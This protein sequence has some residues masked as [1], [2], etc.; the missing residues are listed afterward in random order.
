MSRQLCTRCSA[1]LTYRV[2]DNSKSVLYCAA[3]EAQGYGPPVV[4]KCRDTSDVHFRKTVQSTQLSISS[5]TTSTVIVSDAFASS[6]SVDGNPRMV[7]CSSPGSTDATCLGNSVDVDCSD[8]FVGVDA[9]DSQEA[10]IACNNQLPGSDSSSKCRPQQS[11]VNRLRNQM[12]MLARDEDILVHCNIA[13]ENDDAIHCQSDNCEIDSEDSALKREPHSSDR[14]AALPSSF[15]I[16]DDD[17]HQ[18]VK[19]ENQQQVDGGPS[20]APSET[21]ICSINSTF[22]STR[23]N[24]F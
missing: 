19:S 9:S 5:G 14:G 23:F 21:V 8:N 4:S 18:A 22:D 15:V 3:C 20:A 12:E 2:T 6:H 13:T 16:D 1:V 11:L 17:T 10:E 24:S 7:S